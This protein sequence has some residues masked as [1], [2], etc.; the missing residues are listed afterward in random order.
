MKFSHLG[1]ALLFG[2]AVS[3]QNA[4]VYD[5]SSMQKPYGLVK[6]KDSLLY[7]ADK[8]GVSNY[9]SIG[10]SDATFDF[11]AHVHKDASDAA[12]APL[13]VIVNGVAEPAAFFSAAE[14][15]FE[16]VLGPHQKSAP[17]LVDA[18][19]DVMPKQMAHNGAASELSLVSSSLKAVGPQNQSGWKQ[20]LMLV[21]TTSQVPVNLDASKGS[22]H[23]VGLGA[24]GAA[25]VRDRLFLAELQQLQRLSAAELDVPV[26]LTVDLIGAVAKRTGADSPAYKVAAKTLSDALQA[27]TAAFDVTVVVLGSETAKACHGGNQKRSTAAPAF[28]KRGVVSAKSCYS[29]ESVCQS[30][31][32]DCS[33]HGTCVEIQT[34][35]WQCACASSYDKKAGKTTKWAGADCSKKDL[36]AAAHLLLWTSIVLVGT[37]VVG[38]KLLF[39]VGS[40]SLPGVL[41]AATVKRSG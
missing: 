41:E 32:S 15:S 5:L 19:F 10:D 23:A 11:L 16:I 2:A 1:S 24:N 29:D 25:L 14:P 18:L 36:S 30:A 37:L 9:Y 33:G 38:V 31:T 20:K 12:K 28:A 22:Q 7:F 21:F 3:A 8:L 39:S 26:M 34:D 4:A 35:C 17:E 27:A 40:E 13:V 6:W